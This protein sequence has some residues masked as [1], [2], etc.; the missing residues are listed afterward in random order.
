[1]FWQIKHQYKPRK[2]NPISKCGRLWARNS[3]NIYI[4][5]YLMEYLTNRWSILFQILRQSKAPNMRILSYYWKMGCYGNGIVLFQTTV[6]Q[7]T[8]RHELMHKSYSCSK[9]NL[10]FTK[11][12]VYNI[13]LSI[14]NLKHLVLFYNIYYVKTQ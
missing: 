6:I 1:M 14:H 8:I 10:V 4:T 13:I 9:L 12:S 5:L 11:T 7:C 2:R 3:G